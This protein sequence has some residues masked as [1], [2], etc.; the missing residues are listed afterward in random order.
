MK[1]IRLVPVPSKPDGIS[2]WTVLFVC[3]MLAAAG[4]GCLAYALYHVN[5]EKHDLQLRLADQQTKEQRDELERK[6]GAEADRLT[7]AHNLQ[8][9]VLNQVSEATNSLL[10]FLAASDALRAEASALSTNEAGRGV[11]LRPTLVPLARR[12]YESS[13]PGLPPE[14][15]LVMQLEAVRTAGLAV[16]EHR[17]TAYEPVPALTDMVRKAVRWSAEA[18][19][20]LKEA[21]AVFASLVHDAQVKF[22]RATLTPE[23][24]TLAEAIAKLNRDEATGAAQQA[25]QTTSA[26]YTNAVQARAEAEAQKIRAEAFKDRADADRYVEEVRRKVKEEEAAKQLE[27]QERDAKFQLDVANSKFRAQAQT[28]EA[29][30]LELRKKASDPG[31]QAK[32]APFITPG[33]VGVYRPNVEKKPFS[34]QEMKSIGALEP[35]IRGQDTLV[36]A[37]VAPNDTVRPHWKLNPKF[38]RHHDDQIQMVQEAQ[39]L[40]NELGPVLVEMK[41]LEP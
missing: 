32:L 6:K 14:S 4:I 38:Y 21:R 39:R 26:A 31:I 27:W 25:E 17:G 2:F 34:F 11:A 19:G 30:K 22:T 41:L 40:L 36:Y 8:E 37:G 35:T 16:A 33:Y 24:P 12:F 10:Q 3:F 13:L 5:H 7:L 18:S 29:R 28:D 9:Q 15:E 23:S 20:R 1:D